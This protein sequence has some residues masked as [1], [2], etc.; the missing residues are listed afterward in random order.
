MRISNGRADALLLRSLHAYVR[1][2]GD[3]DDARQM[4][5]LGTGAVAE[6]EDKLCRLV[7]MKYTVCV[8]SATAGLMVVA[9][10]L[11]LRDDAFV[12]GPI[13]YGAS[14]A[15]WLA[16]GNR[17]RFADVDPVTLGLSPEAAHRRIRSTRGTR[18]ILAVDV[19][20]VPSDTRGLRQVAD[21]LGVYY[22][23]DAAQS[24]GASIDGR[25]AGSAAHVLVT[26][27]TVGKTLFTGEGGAVLTDD[28]DIYERVL[29]HGQHPYRQ[30][31]NLGL[32]RWNE[33]AINARMH[34]LAAIWGNASFDACLA[35]LAVRRRQARR[36][37]ATLARSRDVLP[38][39]WALP[40]LEPAV[41]RIS[42]PIRRP[43]VRERTLRRAARVA[44][45]LLA[46]P[47]MTLLTD[48]PAV[49][50]ALAGTSGH[51]CP[52]AASQVARRLVW[53]LASSFAARPTSA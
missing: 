8:A 31:L 47:P 48:A 33:C 37:V 11:G 25:H 26:S 14:L 22:V 32:R 5:L 21:Q 51:D 24:L 39:A 17:P 23:A 15:G 41:F 3:S 18:A 12:T 40:G 44:P 1:D 27:F 34:P 7:G 52:I 42:L 10:A 30:R 46:D 50:T 43:D 6:L 20:G 16:F 19:H 4:H 13:G 35:R 29:W 49:R 53:R 9:M 2:A 28:R 45:A 38:A 36:A